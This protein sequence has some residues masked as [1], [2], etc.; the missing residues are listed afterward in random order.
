MNATSSII[1]SVA[2]IL[3]AGMNIMQTRRMTDLH[4]RIMKLEF[5]ELP[6][7]PWQKKAWAAYMLAKDQEIAR[8]RAQMRPEP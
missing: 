6:V 7:Y 4:R 5:P 8:I 2:I 3:L 1:D